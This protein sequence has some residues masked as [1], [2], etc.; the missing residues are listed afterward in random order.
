MAVKIDT[1]KAGD[2]G[3]FLEAGGED[4]LFCQSTLMA[5]ALAIREAI[6]A[7]WTVGFKEIVI[8]SDSKE[9]ITMLGRRR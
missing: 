8:E 3:C 6:N 2:L 4:G 1:A 9:I 7:S 5:E